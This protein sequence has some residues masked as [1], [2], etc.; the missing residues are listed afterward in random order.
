LWI[1]DRSDLL[2]ALSGRYGRAGNRKAAKSDLA[3]LFGGHKVNHQPDSNQ[4]SEEAARHKFR[5][6]VFGRSFDVID[7][8][9]VDRTFLRFQFQAELF[10]DGGKD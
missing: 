1:G 10:L 5:S 9:N 3:M 7:D 4:T 8:Q 6:L 2:V